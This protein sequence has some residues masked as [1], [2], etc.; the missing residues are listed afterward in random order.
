[1]SH[2]IESLRRLTDSAEPH[3]LVTVVR[4]EGSTPRELGTHM[5]VTEDGLFGTIGGGNLE[6]KAIEIAREMLAEETQSVRCAD[7]ALGPSLAQC[8][9]GRAVLHFEGLGRSTAPAW[10]PALAAAREQGTAGVLVT[11]TDAETAGRLFVTAAE[12]AGSL[13]NA[14]VDKSAAARARALLSKGGG[15]L[16]DK[17]RSLFFEP[18]WPETLHVA[19]FG[20]GHVGRAL[21]SVLAPLPCRI[22]WIDGRAEQ[23]PETVPANVAVRLTDTPDA[24]VDRLARDSYALVMTHS[25]Q[26][27][28]DICERALKRGDLRYVGLIGSKTKRA[29]FEARMVEQGVGPEVLARLTCPIG[30]AGVGGKHPGEIAVAVAAEILRLHHAD[31]AALLE[32]SA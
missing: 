6:Y 3:V 5:I 24:E 14:R 31:P 4:V 9:G 23:F 1:M 18:L 16:L 29:R 27:D 15:A 30:L 7:F 22:T 19:L 12:P 2:W 28:Y 21:V 11:S 8:C 17:D 26:L 25:H 20:A 13:A 32:R 10:L